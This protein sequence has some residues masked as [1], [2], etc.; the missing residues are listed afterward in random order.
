MKLSQTDQLKQK[1]QQAN[2]LLSNL[3]TEIRVAQEKQ[4][5]LRADT[6]A[7]TA[8]LLEKRKVELQELEIASSKVLDPLVVQETTLKRY[9]SDLE[10]TKASLKSDIVALRAEIEQQRSIVSGVVAEIETQKGKAEQLEATKHGLEVSINEL[11]DKLPTIQGALQRMKDETDA[12]QLQKNE[13]KA[14]IL[15]ETRGWETKI[16]DLQRQ[17]TVSESHKTAVDREIDQMTKQQRLIREDLAS[18]TLALDAREKV[19]S[20]REYKVNR[21][22]EIIQNNAGLLNL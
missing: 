2:E 22:E 18:R 12:L 10:L 13:L 17:A 15:S 19:I 3:Q 8:K 7:Q 20:R 6:E 4:K 5:Q 11:N 9:I 21:D 1:Y 16:A 14:L